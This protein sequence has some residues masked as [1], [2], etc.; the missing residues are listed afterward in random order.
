[1]FSTKASENLLVFYTAMT[2]QP[3]SRNRALNVKFN[4][5]K[6][7]TAIREMRKESNLRNQR[8]GRDSFYMRRLMNKIRAVQTTK[9]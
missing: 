5:C 9:I 3:S 8:L 2:K 7:K 1:M 6:Y 4:E